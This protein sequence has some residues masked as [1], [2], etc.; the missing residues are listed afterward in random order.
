MPVGFCQLTVPSLQLVLLH[1][2]VLLLLAHLAE[3]C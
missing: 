1:V 3:R 2:Q